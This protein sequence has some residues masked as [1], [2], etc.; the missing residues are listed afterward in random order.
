MAD[1]QSADLASANELAANMSDAELFRGAMN[2]PQEVSPNQ[3]QQPTPPAPAPETPPGE[4]PRDDKGRWTKPTDVQAPQA[5]AAAT[6]QPPASNSQPAPEDGEIPSW[7]HREIREQRDQFEQRNRQLEAMVL[8]QQRQF[9]QLQAAIN[10]A[11]QQQKPP[12]P[13]PDM[14]THPEAY[15]AYMQNM[16]ARQEQ[17]NAERLKNM[18]AN[19][20]FRLAHQLHGDTFEKAFGEMIQRADR[21]DPTIARAVMASPDPGNAVVGWYTRERNHQRVGADPD[22][23]AKTQWLEEQKK[24]PEFRQAMVDWLNG[25]ARQAQPNGQPSPVQLPPSLNRM[26]ASAPADVTGDLSNDSLF[27][28]AFRQ[29][30]GRR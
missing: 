17:A 20:S 27:D 23:W 18:E 26:S 3:Q 7:R 8:D 10:Q 28:F 16:F 5:P 15:N 11:Q 4:Q 1:D 14:I 19:F 25:E 24:S 13:I 30:R 2:P 12:E 29:G 9:Q 21:G 6:Q 22:A